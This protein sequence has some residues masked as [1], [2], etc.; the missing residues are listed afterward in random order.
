MRLYGTEDILPMWTADMDF[1]CPEPMIEAFQKRVD[2]G[3]FGYTQRD[4]KYFTIILSWLARRFNW[5]LP[6]EAVC[7]SP[8]GVIPALNFLLD[9]LT[10]PGDGVIIHMPNYSSLF[11]IVSAK[12]RTLVTTDLLKTDDGYSIDFADFEA[13]V[14]KFKPKVLILCSPHNPT[15][16]VW[17]HEELTRLCD[18]CIENDVWVISDE[19]HCDLLRSGVVHTPIGS[20]PSIAQKCVTMMAP[21]KTF[22]V[23]GLASS[24]VFIE[25]QWLMG[26]YRKALSMI[27]T[28]LDNVF[29]TIAIDVLY[30]HPGCEQWL[31]GVNEYIEGNIDYALSFIAEN[32]P[33]IWV[34]KPEGTYLLW[35]DFG[36]LGLSGESLKDFLIKEAKLGLIYGNEFG[37]DCDSFARMNMACVRA[38]VVE[39]MQRL[40]GAI[41]RR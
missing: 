12:G 21:N 24:S 18:I 22:N 34:K 1:R 32:L 11:D 30:G 4:E 3:I 13:K 10:A 27:A 6:R 38:T 28:T 31:D 20:I 19:V 17:T 41:E 29:A 26:E 37:Q 33:D 7:W 8:P 35:L 25:N 14:A 5:T 36:K 9:I 23:A 15:G 2:H 39:A 40:K 16:R